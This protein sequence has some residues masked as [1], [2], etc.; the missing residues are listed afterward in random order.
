MLV[1]KPPIETLVDSFAYEEYLSDDGDW[2]QS[3]YGESVVIDNC[4]IDRGSRYSNSASG[5][6][7]LYNAVIFCYPDLTTP[8]PRFA[9]KSKIT[10]DGTEHVITSID[11]VMEPYE[12]K[13]YCYELEVV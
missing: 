5:K 13:V 2:G 1:K 10:Y 8:C 9:E 12:S 7:L 4:R 11:T 6:Q 3:E